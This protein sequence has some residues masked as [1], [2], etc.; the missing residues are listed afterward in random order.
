MNRTASIL[1]LFPRSKALIGYTMR[2][3]SAVVSG[4]LVVRPKR[5]DSRKFPKILAQV[6]VGGLAM[7]TWERI[8]NDPFAYNVK[9]DLFHM[10]TLCVYT[11]KDY[12]L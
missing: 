8:G 11:K 2:I 12:S 10:T 3:S 6:T 4:S 1:C 7:P 9:F 5:Y